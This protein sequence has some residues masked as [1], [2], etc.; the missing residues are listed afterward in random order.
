M[1]K[2]QLHKGDVVYVGGEWKMWGIVTGVYGWW[3]EK[4]C[5][6]IHNKKQACGCIVHIGLIKQHIPR[7]QIK[8]Y[9]R[10]L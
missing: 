8:E 2:K 6:D 1:N 3:I 9:W 10:Y 7:E 4:G 5:V